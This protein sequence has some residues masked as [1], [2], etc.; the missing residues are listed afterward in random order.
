MLIDRIIPPLAMAV[1]VSYYAVGGAY[2]AL[3][4]CSTLIRAA[5]ITLALVLLVALTGFFL[6]AIPVVREGLI[7]PYAPFVIAIIPVIMLVGDANWHLSQKHRPKL[8][9]AR[10]MSR[11]IWGFVVVQRAPL[12]ELAAA[13]LPPDAQMIYVLGPIALGVAMLWYF[14]RKYGGSPF[15]KMPAQ[16]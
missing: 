12:V 10:H 9:M 5:E 11:M 16:G 2:L 7:P 15:G 1:L 13:G 6:A 4:K 14:Q 3:Q 8:R